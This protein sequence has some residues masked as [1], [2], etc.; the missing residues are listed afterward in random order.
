VLPILRNGHCFE[1][2]DRNALLALNIAPAGAISSTLFQRLREQE[3]LLYF[4]GQFCQAVKAESERD[5]S[6]IEQS[7]TFQ[8]GG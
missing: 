5:R 6:R 2:L 3:A 4:G 1:K 7:Q 8:P